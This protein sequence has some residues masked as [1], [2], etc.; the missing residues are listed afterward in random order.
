MLTLPPQKFSADLKEKNG[1]LSPFTF[2]RR[3]KE[4]RPPFIGL[5]RGA[6]CPSGPVA[7]RGQVVPRKLIRVS[8][9]TNFCV[10]MITFANPSTSEKF[11]RLRTKNGSISLSLFTFT[12]LALNFRGVVTRTSPATIKGEEVASATSSLWAAPQD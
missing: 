1:S 4:M 3:N 5:R 10:V 2:F 11:G 6:S 8:T 9:R 7:Y 12:S